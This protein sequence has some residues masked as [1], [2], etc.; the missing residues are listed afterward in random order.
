M[1]TF[2]RFFALFFL[3]GF[4]VSTV[5]TTL[6]AQNKKPASP[7]ATA[8]ATFDGIT[9]TINYAQPSKNGR[10]IF[11]KLVPYGEVWRTGANEATTLMVSNNVQFGGKPLKAGTYSLFTIPA[12]DKWTVIVNSVAKQFG[13]FSYEQAK[14]ILRVEVPAMMGKESTERFTITLPKAG[15]GLNLH[16]MWDKTM[17]SVPMTK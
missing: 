15:S 4:A 5:S 6:S 3:C 8:T 7:P 2:N 12:K 17:V 16:M 9:V 13:A 14:D 10:E 1:R 11:G